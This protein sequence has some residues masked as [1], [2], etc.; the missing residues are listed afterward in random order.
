MLNKWKPFSFLA[1][2]H[3]LSALSSLIFFRPSVSVANLVEEEPYIFQ[4]PKDPVF[5]I[6]S[7][8]K[9]LGFRRFLAG[10]YFRNMVL[11]L[12]QLQVDKIINCLRV[13]SPDF[14]VVFFD[15]MRNEYRFRHSRFSRF[16]V[17]HVLAGQR[18][19]KELRFFLEQMLKEEDFV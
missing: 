6:L 11:S 2:P 3:S 14:A 8:L 16:V 18:R 12:N 4:P 17:A 1:K 10:D 5:E 19:L 7:G 13:E 9:K 15:F